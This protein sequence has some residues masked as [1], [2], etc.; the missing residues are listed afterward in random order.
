MLYP[1]RMLEEREKSELVKDPNRRDSYSS[2]MLMQSIDIDDMDAF[3]FHPTIPEGVAGQKKLP[4]TTSTSESP[5][6]VPKFVTDLIKAS[7]ALSK[8]NDLD[9]RDEYRRWMYPLRRHAASLGGYEKISDFARAF[10]SIEVPTARDPEPEYEA[11]FV[12]GIYA[13]Y[14]IKKVEGAIHES[15]AEGLEKDERV[16]DVEDVL[17]KLHG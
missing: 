15:K 13:D 12:D 8:M 3:Q 5:K 11:G 6:Q 10:Q 17:K 14:A 1:E 16:L 4:P 7:K 2:E 9:N